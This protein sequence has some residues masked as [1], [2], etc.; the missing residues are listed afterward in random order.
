MKVF[1][2]AAVTSLTVLLA[3]ALLAQDSPQ[4]IDLGA[5]P[6]PASADQSQPPAQPL[7]AQQLEDLV[8]PIALYPDTLLSQILAASTY[9]IEVVEAQQWLQQRRDLTGQKLLDEAKKQNWDPSV[10]ALAAFPDVLALLNRD[11]RWTTDLGN[12]FLAQP[13]DVM[14]AAQRLR[15]KA[16]A[17]GKLQSTPQLE[18]TTQT[19][20]G[21]TAIQIQPT[22]PEVIYVP[23]YNPEWVWGPPAY[24]YYPPLF[25]PGLDVGF[26]FL[27]GVDLGLYFGGG[28][29]LWGGYGWGWGPDWF[30]HRIFLD[31]HFFHRYGFRDDHREFGRGEWMHDPGHRLGV[32]YPNRELAGRFQGGAG[33]RGAQGF[34]GAEGA[35]GVEGFRGGSFAARPAPAGRGFAQPERPSFN[36]S[37]S[38]FGGIQGG[39]A[40]RMQSDHGFSSM[41]HAGSGGGGFRGGGGG[42]FHGGGGGGGGH[43]GGGGRR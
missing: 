17:N 10:Q 33:F 42:G 18:V 32:P 30:G 19:Q 24:G 34:R 43:A 20:D 37:H 35:R 39:G 25:Y 9:P 29:G 12:A 16:V 6:E 5:Q 26:S 1:R 41:G 3:A 14:D 4:V 15:A 36:G 8:A 23:V 2:L 31:D 13:A 40:T 22:D 28:W 11:I 21:Q 7:T 27:P 38:A